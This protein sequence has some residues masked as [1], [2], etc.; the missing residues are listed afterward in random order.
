M[1]S[2]FGDSGPFLPSFLLVILLSRY[3]Q[4]IKNNPRIES[5]LK[6]VNSA[7]VAIILA[8]AIDMAK[9]GMNSFPAAA[10]TIGAGVFMIKF[11]QKDSTWIWF[12]AAG[13]GILFLK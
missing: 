2:P 4:R 7:V 3:Y 11:A 13:A 10:I 6:A 12:T 5:G 8:T 1:G 9:T